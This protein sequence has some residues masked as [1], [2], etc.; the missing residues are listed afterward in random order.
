VQREGIIAGRDQ[1]V[2]RVIAG[3]PPTARRATLVI[4]ALGAVAV[5]WAG[6]ARLTGR[7]HKASQLSLDA[8]SAQVVGVM[9]APTA[10]CGGSPVDHLRDA[11]P[12]GTPRTTV[13][14]EIVGMRRQTARRWIYASEPRP[15]CVPAAGDTEV[16]WDRTGHVLWYVAATGRTPLV[17]PDSSFAGPQ[18]P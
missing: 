2:D 3:P 18:A 7:E 5:A 17:M 15:R 8:D 13:D 14:D 12:S 9:G 10:R 11:F 4:L 1:Q 16:G 6:I